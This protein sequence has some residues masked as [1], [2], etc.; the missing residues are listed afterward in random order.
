[1]LTIDS[2]TNF[3]PNGLNGVRVLVADDLEMNRLIVSELL[4]DSGIRFEF[5]ENGEEAVTLLNFS[6]FDLVL[7]DIQMPVMDGWEALRIIRQSHPHL[8]VLAF[9][10]DSQESDQQLYLSSGFSGVLQKPIDRE[11]LLHKISD[12]LNRLQNQLPTERR[13]TVSGKS[14]QIDLTYLQAISGQDPVFLQKMM[15]SF[16]ETSEEI[17]CGVSTAL[18]AGDLEKLAEELH[19]LIFALGIL[20]VGDLRDHVRAVE[21]GARYKIWSMAELEEECQLLQVPLE[22]LKLQVNQALNP[23]R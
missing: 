4:R 19:K 5:A 1:M 17:Q 18:K 20:G 12:S 2:D 7:L 23:D 6:D 21:Q 15:Q 16:L 10:A 11:M 3:D 8:P 14:D 13:V 22:Q 9:S